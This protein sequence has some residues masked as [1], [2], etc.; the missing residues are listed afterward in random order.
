MITHPVFSHFSSF[1][2]VRRLAVVVCVAVL[3]VGL[4]LVAGGVSFVGAQ[5]VPP[6]LDPEDCDSDDWI[7]GAEFDDPYVAD[8]QR[9]C[10]IL[11]GLYNTWVFH[12]DTVRQEGNSDLDTEDWGSDEFEEWKGLGFD[13][14]GVSA[15]VSELDLSNPA[16]TYS[17]GLGGEIPESLCRLSRLKVLRLD[18]NNFSGEIPDCL[19]DLLS[20]QVLDL[21]DNGFTGRIDSGF[22]AIPRLKV[23][24]VG[25]NDFEGSLPA[26]SATF[27]FSSIVYFAVDNNNLFGTLRANFG[28]NQTTHMEFQSNNF[29]GSIPR[30]WTAPR[31]SARQEVLPPKFSRLHV[32]D[33][34][35]NDLTG[36]IDARWLNQITVVTYQH[37][38]RIRLNSNRLCL[39]AN[40]SITHR[41]SDRPT[42]AEDVR[43]YGKARRRRGYPA[44]S[45]FL[46]QQNCPSGAQY[47]KHVLPSVSDLS[48][49]L[50]EAQ[51]GTKQIA[52]SWTPP[53]QPATGSYPR[54]GYFVFINEAE[55]LESDNGRPIV[56]AN[57]GFNYASLIGHNGYVARIPANSTSYTVPLTDLTRTGEQPLGLSEYRIFVTPFY[58][59][60]GTTSFRN[61]YIGSFD[62]F[63]TTRWQAYNVLSDD[64]SAQQIARSLGLGRTEKIYSWDPEM[65]VWHAH[66]STTDTGTLDQGTAVMFNTTVLDPAN[67]Q[68]TGLGRADQYM[69]ILL[70]QGWNILSPAEAIT[71]LDFTEDDSQFTDRNLSDCENLVG[72][73]AIV[74]YDTIDKEFRIGLP[75]HPNLSFSGYSPLQS[76]DTND[77]AY[78]F[79]QSRLAVPVSWDPTEKIYSNGGGSTR[80]QTPSS[81]TTTAPPATTTTTTTTSPPTPPQ[82][83]T[84]TTPPDPPEIPIL[85]T[86]TTTTTTTAPAST[87]TT[88]QQ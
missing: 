30:A 80:P 10:K 64:T 7:Y 28:G 86:T 67:F 34:S 40:L 20:L 8:L 79:F 68:A 19:A 78:I 16:L 32:F 18:R 14:F 43:D 4:V 12:P 9:E 27:N 38:P 11:V 44:V 35:N 73:L 60:S 85:T 57:R 62:A 81:T 50:S 75:C 3:A 46:G 74:T 55:A 54:T 47:S 21:N 65:Q 71:E 53:T 84:T 59:D 82:P 17:L 22:A 29:T 88:M 83:T 15:F 48:K 36:T 31:Q 58:E 70:H 87:A 56:K 37:P 69:N 13:D 2:V 6:R 5:S 66:N 1:F 52:L 26:G 24:N 76:I 42:G 61:I 41:P 25:D 77:I 45:F 33:I 39:P 23:F 63:A 72:V 49:T 51:D